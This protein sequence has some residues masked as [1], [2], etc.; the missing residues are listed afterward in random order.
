MD[1]MNYFEP[2]DPAAITTFGGKPDK[3]SLAGAI[4]V[5]S[6]NITGSNFHDLD[7]AIIGV[8]FHNG[9]FDDD[10]KSITER[11]RGY[12]YRLALPYSQ[13]AI[14]DLGNLRP[15]TTKRGSFLALRD[16]IEFCN[17]MK[18]VTIVIGGS[19]DLTA[20][21]CEAFSND[22][23]FTLSVADSLF[24]VK[25]GI[26]QFSSENFLTGIF[27]KLP[28]LFQFNLI[29]FQNHLVG[30]TLIKRYGISG[31]YLRLGQL[32]DDFLLA[33]PLLRDS[34][35]LSLDMGVINYGSAPATFQKNPNGLR[36]EEICQLS[37]LAGLSNKL[38]VFGL[39]GICPGEDTNGQT[40]KLASEIIW[41]FIEGFGNRK[42]NGDRLTYKVEISGLEQP[43]IFLREPETDR[44]WFEICSLGGK[45][46][47]VACS[48]KDYR[49]AKKNEIPGKWIK[50][51]QKMDNLSK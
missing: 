2:V 12:L 29:G 48:E 43:M 40:L 46:I 35:L 26:E 49:K 4:S 19:Q 10:Q 50:F 20:G 23:F 28:D 24:D 42:G 37:R 11:I 41:Y 1:I 16:I 38:K 15:A 21:I 5:T 13:P 47:E 33:E 32:R 6:G 14:A 36:G 34:D 31:A 39:F 18:V 45:K 25:R 7:I 17:E 30:D 9:K 8:P 22:R 27:K 44:W 3:Y 51:M